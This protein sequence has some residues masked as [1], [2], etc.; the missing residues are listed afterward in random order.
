MGSQQGAISTLVRLDEST[1]KFLSCLEQAMDKVVKS[2]LLPDK[3]TRENFRR[4]KLEGSEQPQTHFIDGD[5][6]ETFPA[7]DQKKQT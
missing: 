7:L 2:S 3:L 1:F 5:F 4:V 6:L